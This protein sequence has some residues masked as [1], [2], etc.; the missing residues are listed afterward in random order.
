MAQ[1][2]E[3][4]SV[5]QTALPSELLSELPMAWASGLMLESTLA[6]LSVHLL[7]M[8]SGMPWVTLLDHC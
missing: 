8:Q 1:M 2:K 3:Q 4:S 5:Q 6:T 7:A